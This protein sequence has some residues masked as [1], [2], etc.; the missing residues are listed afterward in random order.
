MI[1]RLFVPVLS[2]ALACVAAEGALRLFFHAAPQ[3]NVDIYER[4]P[5]G[6]LALRPNLR[7]RHVTPELGCLDYDQRGR[8]A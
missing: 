6:R 2:V 8:S 1:A 4:A 5:D 7:R 3:L